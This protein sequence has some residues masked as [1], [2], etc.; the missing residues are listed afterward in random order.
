MFSLR[1]HIR[2]RPHHEH[3]PIEGV[4]QFASNENL[5]VEPAPKELTIRL[6]QGTSRAT[7]QVRDALHLR[8]QHGGL[9]RS[10]GGCLAD[11]PVEAIRNE[12]VGPWVRVDHVAIHHR[13]TLAGRSADN[14]SGNGSSAFPSALEDD[15]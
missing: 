7:R 5:G 1:R 14:L 8:D 4:R 15:N 2:V 9:G 6:R 12:L 13:M 3:R 10:L 11:E